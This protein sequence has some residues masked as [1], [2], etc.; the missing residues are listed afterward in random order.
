MQTIAP[1]S[2]KPSFPP[3]LAYSISEACEALS[4]G[5]T[6]IFGLI[7]RGELRVVRIGNRTLVTAEALRALLNAEAAQ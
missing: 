6:T 1:T 3:K 2:P 5:R 7:R 4:L